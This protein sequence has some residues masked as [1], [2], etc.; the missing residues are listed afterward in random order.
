MH[1]NTHQSQGWPSGYNGSFV[2][3]H[4]PR[5]EE[6]HDGMPSFM[7]GHSV[8]VLGVYHS[9]ASLTTHADLIPAMM[10]CMQHETTY[11]RTYDQCCIV[12]PLRG[13]LG[14]YVCRTDLV[15]PLRG[16]LGTYVCRTDQCFIVNPL[17]GSLGTYVCRTDQCFIVN[18]EREPG[19]V[20][21]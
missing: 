12:N 20:R 3:R 2:E 16:S 18:P 10:Q 7:V 17:R 4:S 9:T 21:M 13:S 5:C 6:C 14:T 11:V 8:P 15:N 19:N 1:Y